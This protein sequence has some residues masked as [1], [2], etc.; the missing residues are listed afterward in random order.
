MDL[1]GRRLARDARPAASKGELWSRIQAIL[2]CLPQTDIQNLFDSMP[3]RTLKRL[4]ATLN[5]N[6]GH[7]LF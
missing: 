6:F 7:L 3:R 4:V 2:N 1:D 5:T